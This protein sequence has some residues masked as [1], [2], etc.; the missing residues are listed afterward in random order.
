[1]TS[2][3]VPFVF[4][5]FTA[6]LESLSYSDSSTLGP[7]D[8]NNSDFSSI[9]VDFC[10]WSSSSGSLSRSSESLLLISQGV[11]KR[12]R[13]YWLCNSPNKLRRSDSIFNLCKIRFHKKPLGFWRSIRNFYFWIHAFVNPYKKFGRK[14]LWIRI[15]ICRIRKFLDLPDSYPALFVRIRILL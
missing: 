1:M 10:S 11:R 6:V 2:L 15:R 13:L 4:L 3:P 12:C 7:R 9:W 8:G 5:F 14:P